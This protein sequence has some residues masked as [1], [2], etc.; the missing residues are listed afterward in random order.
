M[1]EQTEWM[2]EYPDGSPREQV[3][4]TYQQLFEQLGACFKEAA[5]VIVKAY[6]PVVK[7]FE[8][9]SVHGGY[10]DEWTESNPGP[11]TLDQLMK[12]KQRKNHGP[13]SGDM[14]GLN[15]KRKW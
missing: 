8:G 3:P 13:R 7:A 4:L 6:E 10:Q 12:E 11:P 15:G 2:D 9:I 1:D 14:Y 5:K